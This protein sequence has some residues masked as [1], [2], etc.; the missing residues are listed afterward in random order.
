MRLILLCALLL[1][2]FSLFALNDDSPCVAG[3]SF[4]IVILGSS[5]AAGTGPSSAD[6]A[7]VNKYRAY[8][9]SINPNNEVI[10]LAKGGYTT[11]HIMPTG[12][13]QTAGRPAPDTARNITKALSLN[14][15]A[16][17]VN[18]PSNDASNGFGVAEQM[19]NFDSLFSMANNSNVKIWICTTQPK[20]SLGASGKAIQVGVRDSILVRYG[21][22]AI[23]FWTTIA[24]GN[25]SIQPQFNAD[26]THLN[27]AGHSILVSRVMVEQILGNLFSPVST[28][29]VGVTNIWGFDTINCGTE[30][31]TLALQVTSFGQAPNNGILSS[32]NVINAAGSVLYNDSAYLTGTCAQD[33][34]YI[35]ADLSETGSYQ[36]TA[37][38]QSIY[39][40]FRL[41][42]T[43]TASQ[44]FLGTPEIS[45]FGDTGCIGTS[46]TLSVS[47]NGTDVLQWYDAQQNLLS[48]SSTYATPILSST[49]TYFVEAYRQDVAIDSR[50]A[51]A[52]NT[53]T[54]W[55]GYMFDI[56]AQEDMVLD[57][58]T[59]LVSTTGNQPIELHYKLGSHIGSES[60]PLA[61]TLWTTDT[62]AISASNT[63]ATLSA[64]AATI[65][66]GDTLGVFVNMVNTNAR[67]WY[68][69][70][71]S[72]V[73]QGNQDLSV[74][75]GTGISNG[76]SQSYYPRIFR[77]VVHYSTFT[78]TNGQCHS[79]LIP[80]IAFIDTQQVV[81]TAPDTINIR[82][83]LLLQINQPGSVYWSTGD[84]NNSIEI[85]SL[86][87]LVLGD[88]LFWVEL[89]SAYGCTSS[90]T[91]WVFVKSSTDTI[92]SI[93]NNLIDLGISIYPNPADKQCIVNSKQPIRFL[94][95]R[96]VDE[97]L[98]LD[99]E[100][101]ASSATIDVSAIEAGVYVLELQLTDNTRLNYKLMVGH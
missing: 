40:T 44:F 31:S 24:D 37:F 100:V 15:D 62:F 60:D 90:D 78:Q 8:V 101:N 5:T 9:Q 46:V 4:R 54:D 93:N 68:F 21:Q 32:L 72:A 52:T 1:A 23:D 98:V 28:V 57:S 7:W 96:A 38:T 2:G 87:G 58:I 66:A 71:G 95:L 16:I 74:L 79:Q 61:W 69:N 13:T 53:S 12:W 67:L 84:T 3:Q 86:K 48:G 42:D 51:T 35:T 59:I 82:D 6:S 81:L 10:N 50:F 19:F 63:M 99:M 27:D 65:Q 30:Y 88:N 34:V 41:N 43:I 56:V 92:S 49:T 36:F 70:A 29:D 75:P 89:E 18:M 14:P 73:T 80:V 55:D 47:S 25:H 91:A 45:A 97:R 39:D 33:T 77:G 17:I 22:Y 11:Y 85:D 76:F 94:R 83:T 64:P 26:G 20:T